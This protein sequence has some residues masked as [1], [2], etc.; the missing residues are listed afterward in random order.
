V[1]WLW[2]RL[3]RQDLTV[4]VPTRN[5]SRWIAHIHAYYQKLG[6]SPLYC[7]HSKSSDNTEAVLSRLGAIIERLEADA[8]H[9]EPMLPMIRDMAG[10]P[11]VLRI[12][13][14]ECPSRSLLNWI[15]HHRKGEVGFRRLWLRFAPGWLGERLEYVATDAW[16]WKW[17]PQGEDR[18]FR[19]YRGDLVCY[20]PSIHTPGFHLRK[21]R[22]APRHAVLYHF[23][24]ILR[25][26]AEREAKVA[27]YGSHR[28]FYLPEEICTWDYSGT[29]LNKDVRRLA[30]SLLASTRRPQP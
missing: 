13:D 16:N 26:R 14:D 20:H 12:D 19:L 4:V 25:S 21:P 6:I 2:R 29:V 10:T 8:N 18:Q 9:L 23:D 22:L 1:T 3:H 30:V 11:W 28:H 24:W 5:S 7:V 17:S 15:S 27:R